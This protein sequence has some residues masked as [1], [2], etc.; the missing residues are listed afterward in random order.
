[1]PVHDWTRVSDGVFHDFHLAWIA[2]IRRVL[3]GGLLPANYYALAEQVAGGGNPDVITL[4]HPAPNGNGHA[5][6]GSSPAGG[7]ALLT[8]PPR[9]RLVAQANRESYTARQRTLVIRHTSDHRIVALLEI[10][11]VGNKASDYALQTFVDKAL[12]ALRQGIHL[13][14]L[15]LYPPGVR[16]PQGIHGVLWSR[17]TGEEYVQPADAPLTLAAY[18]AGTVKTAYV[19]PVRVGQALPPMP[20]FLTPEGY[21]EVPL[22]ETYQGAYTVAGGEA[23]DGM[24]K[25]KRQRCSAITECYHR[26]RREYLRQV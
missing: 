16:D 17:L 4:N 11:S 18:S 13:L 6:G 2:E 23:M 26:T 7:V 22:E 8:A 25:R 24:N 12:G 9:V 14:I 21:I 19:E 10:V 3:N 20:L 5:S 15:D 1:M